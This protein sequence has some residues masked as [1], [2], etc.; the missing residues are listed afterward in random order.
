MKRLF[1][2]KSKSSR[3]DLVGYEPHQP[4]DSA[5]IIQGD[6][7]HIPLD[8]NRQASGNRL[9]KQLEQAARDMPSKRQ[10]QQFIQ[11]PLV[12]PKP[13]YAVPP[14]RDIL[15]SY[16]ADK[17]QVEPV[18][19]IV[20]EE[21]K[22]CTNNSNFIEAVSEIS[23]FVGSDKR[24]LTTSDSPDLK[25]GNVSSSKRAP[26]TNELYFLD[27]IQGP[28]IAS[29]VE[30]NPIYES[31]VESP[32]STATN[33]SKINLS[34]SSIQSPS[35]LIPEP[36][37]SQSTNHHISPKL[38]NSTP[39]SSSVKSSDTLSASKYRS[40]R[41]NM[42]MG[43]KN[44]KSFSLSP[45]ALSI[46]T[47]RSSDSLGHVDTQDSL[48]QNNNDDDK[49]ILSQLQINVD[50]FND[51]PSSSFPQTNPRRLKGQAQILQQENIKRRQP[52]EP[53]KSPLEGFE[54]LQRQVE[55]MQRQR[56]REQEEWKERET[57]HRLREQAMLDQISRTQ[58]QLMKALAQS[59]I[60]NNNVQQTPVA[61]TNG[62]SQPVP[63]TFSRQRPINDNSNSQQSTPNNRH[64]RQ[65]PHQNIPRSRPT[66]GDRAGPEDPSLRRR[67]SQPSLRPHSRPNSAQ[68]DYFTYQPHNDQDDDVR[69]QQ[70]ISSGRRPPSRRT[71][72]RSLRDPRPSER[73]PYYD[74]PRDRPPPRQGNGG[75]Q[76][77]GSLFGGGS[78]QHRSR[79]VE[80]FWDE[81]HYVDNPTPVETGYS[82]H[83]PQGPQN[84][85]PRSRRSHSVERA[86]PSNR[87]IYNN[88]P[89]RNQEI[90]YPTQSN[91]GYYPSYPP[92]GDH[93]AE[94]YGY[95]TA[96][97][98]PTGLPVMQPLYSEEEA[99]GMTHWP[100]PEYPI[101]TTH[102]GYVRPPSMRPRSNS[103][104]EYQPRP[105]ST[106]YY[107]AEGHDLNGYH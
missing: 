85:R 27:S 31:A 83:R 33:S 71:S 84:S 25:M 97:Y 45:Q 1:K 86:A 24:Q 53:K 9:Q 91:L 93:G 107:R 62:N 63:S 78:N 37:L 30:S 106:H 12:M 28:P 36:S 48:Q 46:S 40:D 13:I 66:S 14:T 70:P 89:G 79:S 67:P 101:V 64:L 20:R 19:P 44:R 18:L 51:I 17:T 50:Q 104:R 81:T 7:N 26:D 94:Q 11:P 59:G 29:S 57:A 75:R 105:R 34:R 22:S 65:Q 41:V 100:G 5:A 99:W 55:Q 56:E 35:L 90:R 2:S 43:A 21:P 3:K 61:E 10:S 88:Y 47:E 73:S 74:S 68:D 8:H 80:P 103:R 38:S 39:S 16:E 60:I 42:L 72:E 98:S 102:E 15:R 32:D 95:E 69:Y 82:H 52:E 96:Y 77:R 4:L 58:E 87:Q 49:P 6:T 92:Y 23:S 54:T 76:R